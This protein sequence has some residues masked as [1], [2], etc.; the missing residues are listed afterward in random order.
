MDFF[1]HVDI[2]EITADD[3]PTDFVTGMLAIH[4]VGKATAHTVL[5]VPLMA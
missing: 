1:N 2:A 3:S 5:H 4:R